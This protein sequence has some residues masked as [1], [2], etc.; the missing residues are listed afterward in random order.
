MQHPPLP[1]SVFFILSILFILSKFLA[2]MNDFW[3]FHCG[4]RL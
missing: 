1:G 2:K 4:W 3:G